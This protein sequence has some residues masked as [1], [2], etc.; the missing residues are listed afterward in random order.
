MF[1]GFKH[2][3]TEKEF[4]E[5]IKMLY[6]FL[7][8]KKR[9]REIFLAYFYATR[10]CCFIINKVDGIKKD[11]QNYFITCELYEL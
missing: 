8:S 7:P 11:P 2:N 1:F 5:T 9:G 3:S 4:L 6:S 10:K